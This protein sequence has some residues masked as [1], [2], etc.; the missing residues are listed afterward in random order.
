MRLGR[1]AVYP[2]ALTCSVTFIKLFR[3]ERQ[4][5]TCKHAKARLSKRFCKPNRMMMLWY[6]IK[7]GCRPH[8]VFCYLKSRRWCR[9]YH[10]HTPSMDW[11]PP[12]TWSIPVLSETTRRESIVEILPERPLEG[13]GLVMLHAL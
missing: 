9:P 5:E 3:H 13:W 4:M 11:V 12:D 2:S 1:E 7:Y 10:P 6:D 8:R